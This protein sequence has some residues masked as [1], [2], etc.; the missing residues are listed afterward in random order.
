MNY[1]DELD[2]SKGLPIGLPASNLA[3]S[4]HSA[5]SSEGENESQIMLLLCFKP[6]NGFHFIQ[7]YIQSLYNPP[8]AYLIPP[9]ALPL[10]PALQAHWPYCY[11]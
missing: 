7:G 5:H 10:A 9:T 2:Y 6:S 8:K 3:P 4:V 1:C 11:S